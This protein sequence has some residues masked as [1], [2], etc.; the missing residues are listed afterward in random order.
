MPND[1]ARDTEPDTGPTMPDTPTA[2]AA[3]EPALPASGWR[4]YL[5]FAIDGGIIVGLGLATRYSY[6]DSAIALPIIS[7]IIMTHVPSRGTA[8]ESG[9]RALLGMLG[10]F[11]P[12]K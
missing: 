5:H 1:T 11:V 12:K 10:R 8:V 4:R 6:L 2:K 9:L 7:G 3:A